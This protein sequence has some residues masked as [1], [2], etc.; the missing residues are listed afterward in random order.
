MGVVI[1]YGGY[2]ANSFV[3]V[4]AVSADSPNRYHVTAALKPAR[5]TPQHTEEVVCVCFVKSGAF[6]HRVLQ[7][8]SHIVRCVDCLQCK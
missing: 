8:V 5:H 3:M 4:A 2:S 1:L 7:N 6:F